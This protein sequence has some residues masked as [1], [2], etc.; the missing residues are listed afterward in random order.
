MPSLHGWSNLECT[1]ID[2]LR[3]ISEMVH[4]S[5][6]F[7][8]EGLKKI[9]FKIATTNSGTHSKLRVDVIAIAHGTT[10]C[11]VVCITCPPR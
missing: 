6:Q 10:T 3:P 7:I 4:G 2:V 9:E 8:A 1:F 5:A 11:A